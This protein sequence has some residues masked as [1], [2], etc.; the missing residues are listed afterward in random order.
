MVLG[1][2]SIQTLPEHKGF[3][4]GDLRGLMSLMTGDEKHSAAATSTLDVVWVLY[5]R[6][7]DVTPETVDDPA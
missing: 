2:T 4:Y 5:D 7:L 6:I 3:G 1:M